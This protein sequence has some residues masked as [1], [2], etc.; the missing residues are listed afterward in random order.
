MPRGTASIVD[1]KVYERVHRSIIERRLPPG[2]K[3][4]EESLCE[5]FGISRPRVRKVLQ[6]LSHD[7]LV[8]LQPNRGAY[9]ACPSPKE[10]RDVFTARRIIEPAL[11]RVLSPTLSKAALKE[12]RAFVEAERKT[13]LNG[14]RE[15]TIRLSGEFHLLLAALT[16]NE[17]LLK[18]LREL[19]SRT[20]LIIAL[21]ET[22]GRVGCNYEHH[23]ELVRLIG[24]RRAEDAA[25][26]IDKHLSEIEASLELEERVSA[27]VDLRKVLSWDEAAGPYSR[28]GRATSRVA[29]NGRESVRS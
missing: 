18:T 10:A 12:L 7:L 13:R 6:R 29:I 3:L 16:G 17:A 5:I 1:Q 4:R 27:A 21:Y 8:E 9:V 24:A 23:E 19:V 14:D 22:P 15:T 28:L 26:F 11:V 20:S 2:T 25:R